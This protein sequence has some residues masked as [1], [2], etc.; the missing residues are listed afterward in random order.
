MLYLMMVLAFIAS[1]VLTPIVK[2]IAFRVG[3]VDRPN[4]RKV[5]A[6]IMPRLGGLAIFGSFLIAYFI[7]KPQDPISNAI[8]ASFIPRD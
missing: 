6:R 7:L 5:H 3:A 1:I 8:E 4:Y 2:R